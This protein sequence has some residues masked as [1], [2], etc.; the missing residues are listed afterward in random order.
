MRWSGFAIQV[1]TASFISIPNYFLFLER[2]E[3]LE[4]TLCYNKMWQSLLT[5]SGQNLGVAV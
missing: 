3:S 2:V 5:G 1:A 4:E